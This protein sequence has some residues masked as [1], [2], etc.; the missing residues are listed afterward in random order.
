MKIKGCPFC[1]KTAEFK[2]H[3]GTIVCTN[4][5]CRAIGPEKTTKKKSIKAWNKRPYEY[6]D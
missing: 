4:N 5:K 6:K 3:F 2:T 1:G